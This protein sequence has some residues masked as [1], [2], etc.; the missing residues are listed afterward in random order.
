MINW[1]EAGRK[2]LA[3][4]NLDPQERALMRARVQEA[5][6]AGLVFEYKRN[7]TS[8]EAVT[9]F[10]QT[11]IRVSIEDS[12]KGIDVPQ[13][14]PCDRT[15]G[16]LE[17]LR[18]EG[19]MMAYNPGLSYPV[20]GKIFPKMNDYSV[21]EDSPIKDKGA[22]PIWVDVEIDIDAPNIDTTEEDLDKL[23]KSQGRKGMRESTY[24]WAGQASKVLTGKYFDQ[25]STYSRLL[26]S[27]NDGNVVHADFDPDG[28]LL[29]DWGLDPQAHDPNL[30][31]RSEGVKR[32]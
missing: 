4:G 15:P 14:P 11:F 21:N 3:Q 13:V 24:I 19:R 1:A 30:G 6:S 31:G 29:V 18:Q 32:A 27:S 23:F 12:G 9:N 16:E 28:G 2:I 17:A 10:W 5:G 22:K 20:L 7:P 25:G 8:P 26:S